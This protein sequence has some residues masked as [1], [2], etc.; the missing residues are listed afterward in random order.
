MAGIFAGH[1]LASSAA[2]QLEVA[3]W[4][5]TKEIASPAGL[6]DR[7]F[8]E[9]EPDAELFAGAG[10]GLR[11]AR[12][13][14]RDS[15]NEVPYQLVV[16]RAAERRSEMPLRIRDLGQVGDR[17][18]TFIADLGQ[19]G[20]LHNGIEIS[21]SSEGFQRAVVVEGS[22][23]G[24]TWITLQAGQPIFDYRIEERGFSTRDTTVAYTETTSSLLR[25]RIED[26]GE[27]PLKV[28]G[29]RAFFV[30]QEREGRVAY[31]AVVGA[32]IEQAELKATQYLIDLGN[33]GLPSSAI[34]VAADSENYLRRVTLESS[35]DRTEW[36]RLPVTA[37]LYSFD[38][39]KFVGGNDTFSY[40]ETTDR[41]LRMSIVNED[42]APLEVR[43]IRVS[44]VRRKLV[45]EATPGN[46]FDLY[47]GNA[48]AVRPSYDLRH[49]FEY[50]ATDD[51][52][53]AQLG[54]Q[55]LKPGLEEPTEPF[56]ER[57]PWLLPV[58]ITLAA[59]FVAVLLVGV[60]RRAG[61]ALPP[62]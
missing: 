32:P 52:P 61:K 31:T 10:P 45:F 54:A 60:L 43:D 58:V 17:Y 33:S 11:H 39:P 28:I 36:R 9:L 34:E 19:E 42:N 38:T 56:T 29:A 13:V 26:D 25:V 51:L 48:E 4:R 23:D 62:E 16:Q 18:T 27:E 41:Y 24:R 59:G 46:A 1:L 30:E 7:G 40:A 53:L 49:F 5:Y 3:G 35:P 14:E 21:T 22:S 44:G 8:V 20:V 55:R 12:I 15:G 6:T 37:V 57:F 47:Y 50:L 2:A